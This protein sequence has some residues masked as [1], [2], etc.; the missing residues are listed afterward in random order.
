MNVRVIF[1]PLSMV[2]SIDSN[3]EVFKSIPPTAVVFSND[4]SRIEKM[5]L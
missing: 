4:Y 5:K 1:I 3:K 2:E